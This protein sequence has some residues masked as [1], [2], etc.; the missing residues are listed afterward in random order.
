MLMV[1]YEHFLSVTTAVD[2]TPF[3]YFADDVAERLSV[4]VVR[5]D[6]VGDAVAPVA[7]PLILL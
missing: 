3:R 7:Q 2:V 4:E 5:H 6:V 1:F